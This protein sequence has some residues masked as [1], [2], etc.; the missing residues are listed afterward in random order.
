MRDGFKVG[1][2]QSGVLAGF[3]PKAYRLFNQAGLREMVC[4]SFGLSLHNIWEPLLERASDRGVQLRAAGLQ[5]A[6]I[7]RLPHQCVLKGIDRMWNL[8]PAE[9]QLRSNELTKGFLQL[10]LRKPCHG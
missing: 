6:G 8:T 5:Q 3:Q 10:F 4:Q 7:R 2:A 9:Y 1:E